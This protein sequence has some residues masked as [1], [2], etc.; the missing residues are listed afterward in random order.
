MHSASKRS[1]LNAASSLPAEM[2]FFRSPI[3][4]SILG[5]PLPDYKTDWVSGAHRMGRFGS[6]GDL[7]YDSTCAAMTARRYD[8]GTARAFRK[9]IRSLRERADCFP[10]DKSGAADRRGFG[11]TS[12]E[13]SL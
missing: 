2:H 1:A 9:K 8:S 7:R 6:R 13:S 11:Y 5:T 10:P 12:L 3:H 4:P